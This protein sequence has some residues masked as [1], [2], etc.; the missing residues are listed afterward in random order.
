MLR[1]LSSIAP[2]A[3]VMLVRRV[4]KTRT[5]ARCSRKVPVPDAALCT[6]VTEMAAGLLD[7]DLGGSVYK[8]R[9]P[10]PGRDKRGGGR[11]VIGTNLGDR[12]F[13]MFGFLKNERATINDREL[14]ALRKTAAV[15]L[16][17]ESK[18]LGR[19]LE[20]GELTE[21]CHEEEPHSR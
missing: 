5:V 1:R 3:I 12:W 7:A 18:L 9:V 17:M 4:F 2:S 15:L 20:A 6:A 10:L 19:A 13:F 8:K 14:A 21:K 16:A 11:V